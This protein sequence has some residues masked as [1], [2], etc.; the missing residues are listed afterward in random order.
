[1][2]QSSHV[3]YLTKM[4]RRSSIAFVSAMDYNGW[5]NRKT[6]ACCDRITACANLWSGIQHSVA[7]E[8]FQTSSCPILAAVNSRPPRENTIV[9]G[10]LRWKTELFGADKVTLG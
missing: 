9:T 5:I 10:C 4:L 2:K 3:E 1:M 7:V 8:E 6:K